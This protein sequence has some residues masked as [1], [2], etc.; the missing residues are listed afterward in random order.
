MSNNRKLRQ[1][2]GDR[3]RERR[4]MA[5]LNTLDNGGRL[6]DQTRIQYRKRGR[7]FWITSDSA[8]DE[9]A[10]IAFWYIPA[11]D[12]GVFPAGSSRDTVERMVCTYDPARQAVVVI[13]EDGAVSAYKVR[14]IQIDPALN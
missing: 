5:F 4:H 10:G 14:M 3:E 9:P 11:G 7:G 2:G 13:E 6:A 8:S 1:P 12:I